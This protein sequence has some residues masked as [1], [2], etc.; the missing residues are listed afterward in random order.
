MRKLILLGLF[1]SL[2]ALA[3]PTFVDE[4]KGLYLKGHKTRA[5]ELA[6]MKKDQLILLPKTTIETLENRLSEIAWFEQVDIKK[7]IILLELISKFEWKNKIEVLELQEYIKH[8]SNWDKYMSLSPQEMNQAIGDKSYNKTLSEMNMRMKQEV[9]GMVAAR[10]TRVFPQ[11][12]FWI[13]LKVRV[14]D[15]KGLCP[16]KDLEAFLK[17][18][19]QEFLLQ[20]KSLKKKLEQS[21][22]CE[23]G[24]EEG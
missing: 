6:Y 9:L 17:M 12:S 15:Y 13:Y 3:D 19:P 18:N 24:G 22:K 21:L 11:E 4:F 1:F 16:M 2:S 10:K 20:A 5:F 23:G 8:L 14:E 7:Y